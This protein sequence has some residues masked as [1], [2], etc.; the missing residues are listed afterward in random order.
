MSSRGSVRHMRP[1][2]SD[3]TTQTDPVSAIAIVGAAE[4]DAHAQELLSQEAARRVRQVRRVG[5]QIRQP[6]RPLKQLPNLGLVLVQRGHDDVRWLVVSEL[7]DEIREIGLVRQDAGVL[8]RRVQPRLVRGHGL[9]L[10]DLALAACLQDP[11]DD[12]VGFVRIARP[13]HMAAGAC[14]VGLELLEVDVEVAQRVL[15]DFVSGV[16]KGLP[17][18]HLPDDERTLAA[19]DIGGV[20][21]VPPQ[22]GVAERGLRPGR[23][24]RRGSGVTHMD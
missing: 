11:D 15:L 20:P 21:H 7:D 5:A 16:A 1:L 13:V 10:D 17:I 4:T 8:E 22:L 18:G 12:P 9:D 2:P 23:E 3:S 14:A 24:I 6:H 19:D